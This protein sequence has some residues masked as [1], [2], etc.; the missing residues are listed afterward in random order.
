MRNCAYQVVGISLGKEGVIY[1][2][3]YSPQ[4][5]HLKH[6]F[7]YIDISRKGN[8]YLK[9]LGSQSREAVQIQ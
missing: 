9:Q 1:V 8:S 6:I 4:V 3:S 7:G 5:R 2:A